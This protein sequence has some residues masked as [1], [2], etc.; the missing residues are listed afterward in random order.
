MIEAL[1]TRAAKLGADDFARSWRKGKKWAVLYQ[2]RWIHFG[3][4]GYEDYTEHRDPAR[5]ASYR[6]RH[7]GITLADGR[8]AY[9]VKDQPAFWSY[10]VLW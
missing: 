1:R 4:L 9:Q 3:A 10:H 6:R 5:R 2:G 8:L 7:A